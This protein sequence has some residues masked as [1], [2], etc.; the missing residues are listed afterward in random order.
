MGRWSKILVAPVLALNALPA[1]AVSLPN[2][3]VL[4]NYDRIPLGQVEALEGGA[5]TARAEDSLA[6]WYNPA[7]ISRN[8]TSLVNASSEVFEWTTVTVDGLGASP[9]STAQNILPA[10]FGGVLGNPPLHT[11][12]LRIGFGLSRP[13]VWSFTLDDALISPV[14][15][16]GERLNYTSIASFNESN[17]AVALSYATEHHFHYGLSFG[18]DFTS[19]SQNLT[20]SDQLTAGGSSQNSL[21]TFRTNGT[22]T[23]FIATFGTQWD[24]TDHLR[25]GAVLKTPGISLGGSTDMTYESLT[26]SG[27]QTTDLYFH[28]ANAQFRYDKPLEANAGIAYFFEGASIEVDVKYHENTGQY[29]LYESGQTATVVTTAGGGTSTSITESFPSTRYHARS[30]VNGAIGGHINM[31]P[32]L[33]AH[34]GFFT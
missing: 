5:F 23:D 29:Q 22:A 21:Q 34:L 17:V 19:L 1:M 2:D 13:T 25:I 33:N 3:Y 4:P 9:T 12:R 8:S 27:G 20:V 16:G 26:T 11:D 28:D 7:G 10:F 14:S 32:H 24:A 6:T 15:G 18:L 30:V 31:G